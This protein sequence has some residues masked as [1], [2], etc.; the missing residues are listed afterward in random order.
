[1]RGPTN[2]V[3][4]ADS[5]TRQVRRVDNDV[6]ANY[7]STGEVMKQRCLLALVIA[8]MSFAAP[9]VRSQDQLFIRG[10]VNADGQVD[11]VDT[12][13]L[14]TFLFVGTPMDCHNAGDVDDDGNID[15]DDLNHLKNFVQNGT[16]AIPPPYPVCGTDPTDPQPGDDCCQ[17][18]GVPSL[19]L[20]GVLLLALLLAASGVWIYKKR[21][22]NVAVR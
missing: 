15:L 4:V 6:Y 8:L 20:A 2:R 14:S 9:T 5:F 10:D 16:P 17:P 12:T 13:V 22:R 1:M 21:Q 7:S 3:R 11:D 19:T 18:P